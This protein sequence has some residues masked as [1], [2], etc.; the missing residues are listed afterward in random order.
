MTTESKNTGPVPGE[1]PAADNLSRSAQ[2]SDSAAD[3]GN[4]RPSDA[5]VLGPRPV[6]RPHVDNHT[7]HAFRRPSGQN[8][9][10]SPRS[11]A[12]AVAGA[13]TDGPQVQNRPPD[14]VLAEAFGRPE[15]SDELLQRDPEAQHDDNEPA[16]PADPWRDPASAAR[17]GSPEI[18]RAHV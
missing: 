17:L 16:A 15:G 8:G 6:Y 1:G 4:L 7:A 5:P 12:A 18:G 3:R 13:A 10:F 11:A 14:S 2:A 9:S